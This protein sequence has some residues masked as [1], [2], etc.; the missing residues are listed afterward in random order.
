MCRP[1]FFEPAPPDPVHG[2]AN[3]FEAVGRIKFKEDPDGF[4]ELAL[5]QWL[6]L[7]EIFSRH[8]RIIHIT[9]T[10]GFYDQAYTADASFS[11]QI[12]NGVPEPRTVS[13]LSMFTN[14]KRRPEIEAHR[15]AL[16]KLGDNR[17]IVECKHAFEGN[18]DNVVDPFRNIIWSGYTDSAIF[19]NAAH[20]RT[21]LDAHGFLQEHT[22][23]EVVGLQTVSPFYHID[24]V[25]GPLT[26]GEI[27]AHY[28]SL[29]P[30]SRDIFLRKAF[31]ERGLDPGQYLIE[32]SKEDAFSFAT[33]FRC[34]GNTVVMPECSQKLQDKIKSRGYEVETVDISAFL[35]GGGGVHCLSNV[36]NEISY[37]RH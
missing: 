14:E 21:S 13:L 16:E 24:T 8:A 37:E 33:N 34:F 10:P 11:L 31:H 5:Q 12:Y 27:V 17:T 2:H 29:H 15:V 9:P 4:R 7:E 19:S 6:R 3:A 26:N 18:G 20:G 1:D 22:R 30:A 23:I 36:L 35:A 28:K 25:L 32:I